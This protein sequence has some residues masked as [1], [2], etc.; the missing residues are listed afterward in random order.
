[1]STYRTQQGKDSI[2]TCKALWWKASGCKAGQHF[3]WSSFIKQLLLT[4]VSVNQ[5]PLKRCIRTIKRDAPVIKF[6]L[7][8]S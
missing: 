8:Y 3:S 6:H 4:S 2:T 5:N 7:P 1:M